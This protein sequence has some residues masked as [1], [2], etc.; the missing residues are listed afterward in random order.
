MTKSVPSLADVF[1]ASRK[2]MWTMKSPS[3]LVLD[4]EGTKAFEAAIF[5]YA[6]AHDPAVKLA[7]EA[8]ESAKARC[9]REMGL[10]PLGPDDMM[11]QRIIN[12]ILG[13]INSALRFLSGEEVGN[14]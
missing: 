9:D 13:D 1:N 14:G 12:P 6:R 11:V 4:A 10:M 2:T 7:R 5:A 3:T 8:M